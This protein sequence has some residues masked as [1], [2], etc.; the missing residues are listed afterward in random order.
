MLSVGALEIAKPLTHV[1]SLSLI[2]G[3]F[4]DSL[5]IAKVV[6]VLKQGSHML[7]T[8]YRPFSVLPPF[9]PPSPAFASLAC[10][11]RVYFSRYP[12]SRELAHRLLCYTYIL[13]IYSTFLLTLFITSKCLTSP[14]H[15]H[16]S[17][18]NVQL[19]T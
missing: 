3:K 18:L 11:S 15:W 10:L 16:P 13:T 9:S 4:P 7:S 14:F 12:Q 2:Q 5:K 17:S 1:I 19:T 8:N 6:P